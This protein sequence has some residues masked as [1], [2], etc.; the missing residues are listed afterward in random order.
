VFAQGERALAGEKKVLSSGKR[1]KSGKRKEPHNLDK[2]KW[3][4]KDESF[5]GKRDRTGEKK[6]IASRETRAKRCQ[7]GRCG[8]P[9]NLYTTT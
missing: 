4:R 3:V 1:A 9:E 2:K 7:M 8:R 5:R 6:G